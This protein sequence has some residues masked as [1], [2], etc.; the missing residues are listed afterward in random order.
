MAEEKKMTAEEAE[1]KL[2]AAQAAAAAAEAE[3]AAA[4]ARAEAAAAEAALAELDAEEP[5]AEEKAEEPAKEEPKAEEK[6]EEKPKAK[7]TAKKA[8]EK[9]EKEEKA[10]PKK[11]RTAKQ[12]S[13]EKAVE[14][15]AEGKSATGLRIGAVVLWIVALVCEIFAIRMINLTE[16]T[17]TIV[18]IVAD[19]ITCIIGSLLWKRSNKI[20]PPSKKNKFTFFLKSQLGLIACLICFI[21]LGILLLKN[22]DLSPKSKKLIAIIAAVCFLGT[23][24]A[25]IDYAPVSAEEVAHAEAMVA[26]TGNIDG[27]VYWTRWGKSYHVEGCHTLNNTKPENLFSGTVAEAMAEKRDDPCDFCFK[28]VEEVDTET[29]EALADGLEEIVTDEP[30]EELVEGVAET[31]ADTTE[32]AA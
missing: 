6:A 11:K 24:G 9:D 1:A 25:S 29:L 4:K 18:F 26:A 10:A 5:K 20:D 16:E 13:L 31:V 2:K 15:R 27:E 32:A 8:E 3:L 22:Q 28:D 30:A 7:K 19:A 12:K 14:L 17:L 21:P 23:A